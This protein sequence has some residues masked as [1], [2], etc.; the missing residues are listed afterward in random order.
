MANDDRI[1]G[2]ECMC[3]GLQKRGL[4]VGA[5]GVRCEEAV[6]FVSGPVRI[7]KTGAIK[8]ND[9]ETVREA[10]HEI[11]GEFARIATRS[12]DQDH[13]WALPAHDGMYFAITYK[14]ELTFGRE[15]SQGLY[16]MLAGLAFRNDSA[17]GKGGK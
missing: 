2:S 1:V 17:S 12:V 4:F 14:N 8:G 15:I 3:G 10:I 6:V 5:F 7:A 11:K 9:T 16:D 13:V